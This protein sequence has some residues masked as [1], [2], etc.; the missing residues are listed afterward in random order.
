MGP[1]GQIT[2]GRYVSIRS[3]C[4][5]GSPEQDPENAL[6]SFLDCSLRSRG[7]IPGWWFL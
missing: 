2:L 7:F 3:G 5:R 4:P 6:R 1:G